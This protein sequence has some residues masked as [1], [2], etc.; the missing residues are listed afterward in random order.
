MNVAGNRHLNAHRRHRKYELSAI[1]WS[2]AIDR[3]KMWIPNCDFRS[4]SGV[5]QCGE[6]FVLADLSN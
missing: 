6:Q 3:M 2:D 4:D 1:G 5:E